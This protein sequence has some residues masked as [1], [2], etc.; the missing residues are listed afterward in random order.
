MLQVSEEFIDL[1]QNRAVVKVIATLD[2]RGE[3]YAVPAPFLQWSERGELVHLEPLEKSA[4]N[5]NLLRSLWFGR[6][7]SVT[8]Y[9]PLGES[10]VISGHPIKAHI[11]GP[12]FRHYYQQLRSIIHDADLSTAWIIKPISI[13]DETYSRVKIK[14]EDEFP[15]SVHLDRLRA[16]HYTTERILS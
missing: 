13:T 3:P 10:F 4:T 5:R 6:T 1:I 15:F 8:V 2:E 12:L 7:V 16:D 11:C 14:E 9:G